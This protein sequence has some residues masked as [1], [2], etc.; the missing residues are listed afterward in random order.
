MSGCPSGHIQ[1]LRGTCR[2]IF[3]YTV[4]YGGSNAG[5][6][7]PPWLS[8]RPLPRR[9][10]STI[11]D[12][13]KDSTLFKHSIKRGYVPPFVFS[14][15]IGNP[16]RR[17]PQS[18]RVQPQSVQPREILH[19]NIFVNTGINQRPD[20]Q[21]ME[22]MISGS[23]IVVMRD[24]AVPLSAGGPLLPSLSLHPK[25]KFI[26]QP[27]VVPQPAPVLQPSIVP[28]PVLEPLAV[29]QPALFSNNENTK[30]NEDKGSGGSSSENSDQRKGATSDKAHEN[31]E[32]STKS[33]SDDDD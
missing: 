24:A 20:A 31:D 7:R 9:R 30:G 16:L 32:N 11:R 17:R 13:V 3:Q 19:Q 21:P 28:Q 29:H 26:P 4:N 18:A 1:D 8:N 15:R 27:V 14:G 25:H 22:V 23:R 33:N 10:Q 2:Q 12:I 6:S 5:A